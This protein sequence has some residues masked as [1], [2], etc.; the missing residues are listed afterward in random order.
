MVAHL[1]Y[2]DTKYGDAFGDWNTTD[3]VGF[4]SAMHLHVIQHWVSV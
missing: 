1:N 2:T 3:M 4:L